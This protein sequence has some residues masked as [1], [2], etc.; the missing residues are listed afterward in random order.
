[1]IGAALNCGLGY[2]TRS[3][4]VT[5]EK[6]R[7]RRRRL[8]QEFLRVASLPLSQQADY[9]DALCVKMIKRFTLEDVDLSTAQPSSFV[10][11]SFGNMAYI[12]LNHPDKDV[13]ESALRGL[14]KMQ[15]MTGVK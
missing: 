2:F 10:A 5:Y 8:E 11:S 1:M 6:S 4:F 3:S 13:S 12:G 9:A 14:L 7:A 15:K